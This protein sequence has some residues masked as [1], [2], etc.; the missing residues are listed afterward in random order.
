MATASDDGLE[1]ARLAIAAL[2]ASLV[3]TMPIR[4]KP[5]PTASASA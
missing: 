5:S 4:I 2:L 3:Q 1:Q